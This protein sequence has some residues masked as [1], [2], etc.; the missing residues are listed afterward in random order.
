MRK[1]TLRNRISPGEAAQVYG[2]GNAAGKI[3]V[4]LR[5]I[6]AANRDWP[7]CRRS[8]WQIARSNWGSNA[9]DHIASNSPV[10]PK[11]TVRIGLP[12]GLR[13]TRP[14]LGLTVRP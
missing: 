9:G 13:I 8:V 14:M 12:S 11:R 6:I 10:P 1:S 2:L 3:A 7:E 5:T 4:L